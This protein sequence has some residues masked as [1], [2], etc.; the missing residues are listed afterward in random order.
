MN[1]PKQIYTCETCSR[2]YKTQTAFLKHTTICNMFYNTK[3]QNKMIL[4]RED[5]PIPSITDLFNAFKD[6]SHKYD[7]LQKDY[8][9]LKKYVTQNNKKIDIIEFLNKL[10]TPT[11]NYGEWVDNLTITFDNLEHIF[12][13]N[14]ID[15]YTLIIKY[16]IDK[17]NSP[18]KCFDIKECTF[19]IYDNNIWRIQTKEEFDMIIKKLYKKTFKTFKDWQDKKKDIAQ[20]QLDEYLQKICKF[21]SNEGIIISKVKNKV[22]NYLKEDIN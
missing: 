2:Q 12:K 10:E 9:E 18:I 6:L 4:E 21:V 5:E 19:Y 1:I 13:T 16:M 22:Y 8:T 20:D 11:Q 3:K 7:K 14:F 17:N 15:C